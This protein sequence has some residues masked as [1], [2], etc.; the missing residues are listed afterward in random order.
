MAVHATHLTAA[1]IRQLGQAGAMVCLCRTT[2]RD[3]GDGL[4]AVAEMRAAGVRLCVGADSH[5]APDAFEEIRAVEL[6]DRSRTEQRTVAATAPD[7]LAIGTEAGYAALGLEQAAARDA[8]HLRADDAALAGAA[9]ALLA[10]HVIFGATARAVDQVFVGDNRIV[11]QG[12]HVIYEE[13][14]RE[15]TRTVSRIFGD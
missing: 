14:H 13:A 9:G 1:E 11:E 7:L 5:C 3:L 2:E 10:D 4:P 15:F 6:D 8:V 12:Q